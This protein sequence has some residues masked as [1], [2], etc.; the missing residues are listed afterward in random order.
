MFCIPGTEAI[1]GLRWRFA[2]G[3]PLA[4]SSGQN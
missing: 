4:S 2:Q 3:P 1:E